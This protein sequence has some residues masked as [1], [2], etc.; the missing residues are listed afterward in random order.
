MKLI[1]QNHIAVYI[2]S[3]F[4]EKFRKE[5]PVV[6]LSLLEVIPKILVVED[7]CMLEEM[8]SNE[9]IKAVVFALSADSSPG[10]DGYIRYFY[11]LCW[12]IV[13]SDLCKAVSYLQNLSFS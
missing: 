11:K 4:K 12:S 5:D 7:N 9:E 2:E 6:D 13:R 1:E 8:P 3:Y 10:L